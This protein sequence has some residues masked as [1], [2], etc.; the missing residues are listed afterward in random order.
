M[1]GLTLVD[2]DILVDAGRGV[3]DAA[4]YLHTK[5]RPSSFAV[6]VVTQMELMVGCRNRAELRKL[7]RFLRQFSVMKVSHLISD[8][9]VELLR[10]YRLSHGLLIADSLIAATALVLKMP[11]ATNNQRDFRFVKGL[12]LHPYP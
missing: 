1:N 7:E 10:S 3:E 8:K 11:F 12:K 5:H 2:T 6:S 4:N 9:A